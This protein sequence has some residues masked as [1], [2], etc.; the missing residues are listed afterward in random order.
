LLKIN[1]NEVFMLI[2][3]A[4]NNFQSFRDRTEVDLTIGRK[5]TLTNW[6]TELPNGERVSKLMA[7]I[8]ANGSGKTTLLKPLAFLH[9]F[10]S[11]SFKEQPNV[12]IPLRSFVGNA[13]VPTEF[14][15]H[16]FLDDHFWRY[17]LSCTR[18]KVQHEALYKKVERFSYVFK[19]DWDAKKKR[20]NIKQQDFGLVQGEAEKVR[21]NASL[22]ATAAQY[23]VPLALRIAALS[24]RTNMTVRGRAPIEMT[25]ILEAAQ[26]MASN[27]KH[28][29][30]ASKLLAT[31]DLGLSGVRVVKWQEPKGS[32]NSAPSWIPMGMHKGASGA[33]QLSFGQE[34][35]GTQSAF[36][37][38]SKLLPVLENGGVAVID[39]LENDLHPHMLEPILDLFAN[40]KSNPHHAQ[41][42]FTSHALEV[43]NLLHK[44]QVM[45]VKKDEHCESSACRL[46]QVEGIRNDDNLYAK[47]MAGA[48][49]AIPNL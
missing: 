18:D 7:V 15:V 27:E 3:Y 5:S 22:I 9:W 44:S 35:S 33:F 25:T 4:F 2:S 30:M 19:R 14:E 20:Y 41:L 42:I 23:N 34:S 45:L 46:D 28:L 40:P 13:S 29:G 12:S 17:E 10:V 24:V 1:F 48:Y 38:L 21:G 49:S 8:G 6:M 31:W 39:E 43:L 37:L 32:E 16:F 36:V 47:Y 26:H 11:E